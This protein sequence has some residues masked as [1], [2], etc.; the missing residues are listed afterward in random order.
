MIAYDI[1]QDEDGDV[2]IGANGDFGRLPSDKVHV[3][4]IVNSFPGWW[5]QF[6]LLG[7]RLRA[8]INSTGKND[9]ITRNININLQSDKYKNVSVKIKSLDISNVDIQ[10][11]ADRI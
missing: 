7:A 3:S 6:P 11:N 4:D 9:E 5:K 1:G 10:V 2:F 8:Y